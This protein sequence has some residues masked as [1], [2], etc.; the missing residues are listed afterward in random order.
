[1]IH[2][3]ELS[4]SE[5]FRKADQLAR[6][7]TRGSDANW[8]R[9]PQEIDWQ[10]HV[11]FEGGREVVVGVYYRPGREW[12][13]GPA[14]SLSQLATGEGVDGW[15]AQVVTGGYFPKRVKALGV[16]L[17]IADECGF[18]ALRDGAVPVGAGDEDFRVAHFTMLEEPLEMLADREVSADQTGWRL[19]PLFGAVAGAPPAVA[20][21]LSRTRE[22]WLEQLVVEG[23][24]L[25]VPVRVGWVSAPVGML[26]ALPLVVPGL[27]GAVVVVPYLKFTVVAAVAAAGELVAVR[28]LANR[29][30]VL[31]V[32]LG[33]AV[34]GMA[35][36]AELAVLGRPPPV[37]VV[38]MS[39]RVETAARTEL[40][41][42]AATRRPLDWKVVNPA[43][44]PLLET[45]PGHRPELLAGDAAV[46]A[47]AAGETP[48]SRSRT[49]RFLWREWPGFGNFHNL[50]KADAL[51]PTR[52][53]LRVLKVGSWVGW[54]LLS[55][56]LVVAGLTVYRF[57]EARRQP[58]WLLTPAQ[59]QEVAARLAALKAEKH[60]LE[61]TE[62]LM[63]PRSRGWSTLEIISRLFPEDSG[64][65][66]D[67][68]QYSLAT[69]T[70]A[71][72]S[73]EPAKTLGLTRRLTL[74]GLAREESLPLLNAMNSNRT[75]TDRLKALAAEIGDETYAVSTA[76]PLTVALTVN[77]NPQFGI[78][79]AEDS[80]LAEPDSSYP[81]AFEVVLTVT[82]PPTDPYALPIE[83]PTKLTPA[84]ASQP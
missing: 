40:A 64:V 17:H 3:E 16:I 72:V 74:T 51:Y 55:A 2:P 35:L 52:A 19:L 66:L 79:D 77:R 59:T 68:F 75:M 42:Y 76:R 53:D 23:E 67:G 70:P 46:L 33:D 38:A 31:P 11:W 43:G 56:M 32:G 18:A 78:E 24:A 71:A 29:G 30:Q 80:P 54:G 21:A 49:Y 4:P 10:V 82:L 6:R 47:A 84:V 12:R 15:L 13:A 73:T 44:H 26:A 37:V 50:A 1:M 45:V 57:A 69:D 48:E 28:S 60:Q 83:D 14:L 58:A 36:A 7:T 22:P 63:R 39:E 8:Y 81:Y 61:L 5:L 41:E 34:H 27:A 20:V 25:R 65:R 62:Q 9:A